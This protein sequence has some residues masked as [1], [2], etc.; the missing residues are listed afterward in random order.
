MF[1]PNFPYVC[2]MYTAWY[3]NFAT[4]L[5]YFFI[6]YDEI[7]N[8]INEYNTTRRTYAF[9]CGNNITAEFDVIYMY[10]VE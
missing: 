2:L 9:M 7:S 10:I 5:L 4:R 3:I 6:K 8:M 1:A